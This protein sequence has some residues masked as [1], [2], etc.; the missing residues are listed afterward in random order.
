M[1][2]NN[3]QYSGK[4][5]YSEEEIIENSKIV[6]NNRV[7]DSFS[8]IISTVIEG[9]GNQVFSPVALYMVMI[10]L[11]TTASEKTKRQIMR[12]LDVNDAEIYDIYTE[13]RT[14]INPGYS[15]TKCDIASSMWLNKELDYNQDLLQ[16]LNNYYDVFSYEGNMGDRDM[17][18]RIADWI[19]ANTGNLLK[20]KVDIRT[21]ILTVF[22]LITTI[23]FK[24]KWN[25]R[26]TG[27]NPGDFILESGHNVKCDYMRHKDKARYH[28]GNRF[29]AF[30]KRLEGDYEAV[31]VLPKRGYTVNELLHDSQVMELA[32]RNMISTTEFIDVDMTIPQFDISSKID[33]KDTL[34]RLGI[35]DVFLP[36]RRNHFK[37]IT[38]N[39]DEVILSQ[40]EQTTRVRVDVN[41]IEA[42]SVVYIPGLGSALPPKSAKI[43]L[44]R[45]FLF[46]VNSKNSMPIIAGK[47]MN[48]AESK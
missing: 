14:L 10:I 45:P 28:P 48:P 18:K 25:H 43:V 36:E 19:N 47:V 6:I 15:E 27:T 40:A 21:D 22:V 41:G 38:K 13:I 1:N 26:F 8:R 20:N 2:I 7:Y 24:A 12:L 39:A 9:K 46:F 16:V 35:N 30:S 23:Y 32:E 37:N 29:I 33:L 4:R 44:D 31:F 3:G 17:D 11:S 5:N 42:A 34:K